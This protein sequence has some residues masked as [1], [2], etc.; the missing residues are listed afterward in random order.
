MEKSSNL[1]T[2]AKAAKEYNLSPSVLRKALKDADMKPDEVKAGCAYYSK[3]SIDGI[4][5][6]LK[7]A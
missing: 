3:P 4:V 6:K 2:V 5:K 7:K 1:L